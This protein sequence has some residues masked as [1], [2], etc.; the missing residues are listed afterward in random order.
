MVEPKNINGGYT[1]VNG[2]TI[3]IYRFEECAKVLLHEI[4]HHSPFDTNRLWKSEQIESIRKLCN[5]HADVTL[6]I[7]EAIIEF[8]A[9]FFE[10]LFISYEYHIPVR[11][12]LKREQDWS[13]QQSAKLLS[14][15]QSHFPE[16]KEKTNS[17][18]YIVIKSILLLNYENFIR[19]SSP[20]SSEILTK[21][22]INNMNTLSVANVAT[23]IKLIEKSSMRMTLFGDI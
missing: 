14:Y 4:L 16:W 10:A 21:F 3:F 12:L 11:M 17:Y 20:Y 1:Y 6:N 19:I 9:V 8:W 2:T 13:R 22:I 15:Q 7:N 5:I 23:K 18:C